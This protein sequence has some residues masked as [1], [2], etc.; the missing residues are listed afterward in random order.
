VTTTLPSQ[1]SMRTQES[2][3]QSLL[4]N[5]C[6]QSAIALVSTDLLLVTGKKNKYDGCSDTALFRNER[7]SFEE[8]R[9]KENLRPCARKPTESGKL[10]ESIT[11]SHIILRRLAQ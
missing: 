6:A 9:A 10:R 8:P 5:P 4:A 3:T 1:K 11:T 2:L 7:Y